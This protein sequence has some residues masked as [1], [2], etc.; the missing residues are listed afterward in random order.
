MD[1]NGDNSI[2]YRRTARAPAALPTPVPPN[3]G[4]RRAPPPEE[5]ATAE[6]DV[7]FGV[8]INDD[9]HRH[10]VIVGTKLS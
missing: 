5:K 10:S 3:A 9:R 7:S 2:V 8:I 4:D 1:E 6:L